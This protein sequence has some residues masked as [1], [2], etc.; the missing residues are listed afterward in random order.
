MALSKVNIGRIADGDVITSAKIADDSIV[1]ADLNSSAAI[2]TSKI[3]PEIK[4]QA[5]A[6]TDFNQKHFNIALLGFKM[7]VQDSLTVFNLVD[8]VV[9]E[10]HDESGTDEAEGSNDTYCSTSDNYINTV[11]SPASFSAG[12]GVAS[13]TEPDTSTV[14]VDGGYYRCGPIPSNQSTCGS[15]RRGTPSTFG[16][17]TVP[18]GMTSVN[19]QVWGAGGGTTNSPCA[20]GGGGGYAE[21]T[22]A[23]TSGQT[24]FTSAGKGGYSWGPSGPAGVGPNSGG[25]ISFFGG[26]QGGGG[27][28]S[29]GGGTAGLFSVADNNLD[30]APEAYL[31][32]G[33][34]GGGGATGSSDPQFT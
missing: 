25:K 28:G 5:D 26:G 24:L 29:G 7:A 2:A 31:V 30:A 14:G 21:G 17:F 15:K 23:V 20:S 34:G 16:Q 6:T 22:L 8:G 10:F 32:G 19:V 18:T 33:S 1:N 12:F 9:D 11:C 3:S 13:I 4:T 27:T